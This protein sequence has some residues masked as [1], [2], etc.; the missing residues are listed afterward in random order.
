[1]DS[2]FFH[3]FAL[4]AVFKCFS[5]FDE[6]G[7][8]TVHST[9][10][11]VGTGQQKLVFLFNGDDDGGGNPGEYQAA[12]GSTVDCQFVACKNG[13]I[14]AATTELMRIPPV[15]QMKGAQG[16]LIL[17]CRQA[18]MKRPDF[19]NTKFIGK[20]SG[21]NRCRKTRGSIQGADR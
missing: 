5:R 13:G 10:K 7:Q 6:S 18:T 3:D 4:Y 11:P 8:H 14:A 15:L 9:D 19:P 16:K 1:M 2:D 17:C 21:R 20:R 12:A